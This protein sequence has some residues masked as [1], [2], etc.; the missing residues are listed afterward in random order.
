MSVILSNFNHERWMVT[1]T[2]I[3]AQRLAVEESLKWASQRV[4]FGKPLHAQPVIRAKLASMIARVESC[5]NWWE[6]VTFQ[7]NNVGSS[8]SGPIKTLNGYR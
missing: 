4:V 1:A 7:M 3:S 6:S 8:F 5:Q 2:S